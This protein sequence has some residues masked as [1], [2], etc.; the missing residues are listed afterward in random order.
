MV[1]GLYSRVPLDK[2]KNRFLIRFQIKCSIS[3]NPELDYNPINLL[4]KVDCSYCIIN[5]IR[6]VNVPFEIISNVTTNLIKKPIRS[7]SHFTR[8]PA[9][10]Q[11]LAF[12][13]Y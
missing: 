6:I 12:H 4:Q 9:A 7:T 3:E 8:G 2:S 13:L 1:R 5:R 10:N 11:A